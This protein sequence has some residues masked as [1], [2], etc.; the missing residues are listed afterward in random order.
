MESSRLAV[1]KRLIGSNSFPQCV[2]LHQLTHFITRPDHS[3]IVAAFTHFTHYSLTA[4]SF[5][6][7]LTLSFVCSCLTLEFAVDY[8]E[9]KAKVSDMELRH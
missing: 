2:N 6:T 7:S 9:F 8:A 5:T 4:H 3:C 1:K